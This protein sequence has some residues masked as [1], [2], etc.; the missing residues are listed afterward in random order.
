VE[1]SFSLFADQ[2]NP[3][4]WENCGGG[5]H[6]ASASQQNCSLTSILAR[7]IQTANKAVFTAPEAQVE[8]VVVPPPAPAIELTPLQRLRRYTDSQYPDLVDVRRVPSGF[9]LDE[10]VIATAV[11]FRS[12][13]CVIATCPYFTIIG[14]PQNLINYLLPPGIEETDLESASGP[15]PHGTVVEYACPSGMRKV[16]VTISI[17]C[18]NGL[19]TEGANTWWAPAFFAVPG[20]VRD[21]L[22]SRTAAFLQPRRR[23]S[24]LPSGSVRVE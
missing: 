19:F 3:N 21:H 15:Y 24:V 20:R 18:V 16:N 11:D 5:H 23:E 13:R 12:I 7:D 9:E 8:V 6:N 1:T 14:V 22:L 4:H 10:E 17:V 2:T